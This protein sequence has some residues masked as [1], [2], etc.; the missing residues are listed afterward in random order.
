MDVKA[1]IRADA[2][3]EA[4][5]G[6]ALVFG[7]AS[8][9][10]AFPDPVGAV[11]AAVAGGLLLGLAVVLW[12]SP[13]GLVPLAAGNVVTALVAVAWLAA[14]SGFSTG[15]AAL[16]GATVAGLVALAAAELALVRRV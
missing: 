12:Q 16:L 14:A 9:V 10:V 4:A 13:I 7:A 15:G 8:G 1:V 2:V 6:L 3:F 11:A 5:L